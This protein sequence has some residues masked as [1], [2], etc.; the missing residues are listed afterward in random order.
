MDLADFKFSTKV[1]GEYEIWANYGTY[2]SNKIKIT[3][4]SV[5]IPDAPKDP[6][7]SKKSFKTRVLITEF[8]GTGCG[9]CPQ[10]KELIHETL[11]LDGMKEKVVE[12]TSH[13]FNTTDKAYYNDPDFPNAFGNHGY[14][15]VIVDFYQPFSDYR[16]SVAEFAGIVNSLYDAKME[17]AAGISVNSVADGDELVIR[18]SM[19]AAETASYRIGAI[20]VEDGIY[21]KQSSATADWMHTHN[22]VISHIDGKYYTSRYQYYGHSLGKVEKGKTADYLFDWNLK[23]IEAARL[24]GGNRKEFVRENLHLVIYVSSIGKDSSGKEFYY[25]NNVVEAPLT[26][27][28]PFEYR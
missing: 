9:I 16:K 11:E 10:M 13:T 4:V 15:Y 6:Q 1:S 25:I 26:G 3:A 2:N 8:T 23:E 17:N 12:I 22:G 24:V 19:K 27:Q 14:P 18:A 28:L 5:T 7:P 21:G 20:L